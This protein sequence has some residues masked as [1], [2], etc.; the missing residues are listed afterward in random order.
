MFVIFTSEKTDT[1]VIRLSALFI[2]LTFENYERC[3]FLYKILILIR[4]KNINVY[5][6]FNDTNN[7]LYY[8]N[9]CLRV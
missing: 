8:K 9:S 1:H 3:F 7:N 6:F 5:C 4:I 2:V